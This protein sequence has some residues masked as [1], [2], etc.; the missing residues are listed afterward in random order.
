[1]EQT[2]KITA[3]VMQHDRNSCK[4]T[5]DRVLTDQ[6]IIR[7]KD[8]IAA[9][10]SPLAEGIFTIEGTL[11]VLIQGSDVVVTR[12]APVD[13]RAVGPQIGGAIRAHVA[14]GQP[15][16]LPQAFKN[17]SSEDQLRNKVQKVIDE[18]INPAVAS[19]GGYI[20]LIDVKGANI[21]IQMGGGCQGCGQANVT[22]RDG[23]EETMRAQI[24]ELGEIL[25]ATDHEAGENPFYAGSGH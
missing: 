8:P 22:L 23:V 7:F 13:W 6:G 24:P 14:S 15:A 10:D 17:A 20:T 12:Q 21:Y 11:A 2:I 5:V 9:K 25:D 19:H 4:F 16:V 1:M 3:E 18:Q